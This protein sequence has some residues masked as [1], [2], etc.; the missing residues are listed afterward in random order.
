MAKK[1]SAELEREANELL[2]AAKPKR[3]SSTKKKVAAA[4]VLT[5][6]EEAAAQEKARAVY[7]EQVAVL[8]QKG[9]SE[10]ML[11]FEEL[12]AF[13]QKHGMTEEDHSELMRMLEKDNVDLEIGR[14]HV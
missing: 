3:K 12:A 1:T 14:A 13:A 5:P 10:G 7:N 6:E 8:L 4:P 9:R 2:N 11:T